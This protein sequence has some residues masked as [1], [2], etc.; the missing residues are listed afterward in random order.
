MSLAHVAGAV[1]LAKRFGVT[2]PDINGLL[3]AAGL[4][5]NDAREAVTIKPQ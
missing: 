4:H 3:A 5:W 1:L 2:D